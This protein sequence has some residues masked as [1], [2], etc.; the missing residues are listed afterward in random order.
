[1]NLRTIPRAA[2]VGY[3]RLVRLPFDAAA[4]LLPGNGTGPRASARLAVDRAEATGLTIAGVFLFDPDL[5]D[6]AARRRAAAG[7]RARA[8]HLR[9][10]A[11]QRSE[12]ADRRISEREETAARQREEAKRKAAAKRERAGRTRDERTRSAAR[13]ETKRRA[14]NRRTAAQRREAIEEQG[15]KSR[16]DALETE[17]DAIREKDE[18]LTARDEARRLG[19]AAGRVKA[20]RKRS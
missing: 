3:A 6:E 1:M 13:T 4:A 7:E 5:R 10:E 18:A 12:E 17:A 9:S 2:V 14:S 19:E 11:E 8:V 20:E 15:R 16:L